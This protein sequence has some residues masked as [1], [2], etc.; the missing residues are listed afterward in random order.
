MYYIWYLYVYILKLSYV[1][2]LV[3]LIVIDMSFVLMFVIL[4]ICCNLYV[5]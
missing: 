1:K 2:I 4:V 5:V 3:F